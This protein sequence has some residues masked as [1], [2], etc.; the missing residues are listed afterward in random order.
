MATLRC[1]N[2]FCV[3]RDALE[4]P[5]GWRAFYICTVKGY[6]SFNAVIYELFHTHLMAIQ[7]NS[8]MKICS[9]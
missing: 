7:Q 1:F 3:S 8:G 5:D 9:G 2:Q 6:V 4:D